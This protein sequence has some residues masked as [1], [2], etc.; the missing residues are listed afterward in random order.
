[1]N[2]RGRRGLLTAAVFEPGEEDDDVSS[3]DDSQAPAGTQVATQFSQPDNPV[4]VRDQSAAAKL[5]F[6]SLRSSLK[7]K[8]TEQ[9]E[10]HLRKQFE[11]KIEKIQVEISSMNPNM[12]VRVW[13]ESLFRV[14]CRFHHF[15]IHRSLA[16]MI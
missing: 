16:L 12:K 14:R 8:L 15:S 6:S 1:M 7:Q 13:E 11:A 9:E 5:D 4:V 2:E 3:D 10:K